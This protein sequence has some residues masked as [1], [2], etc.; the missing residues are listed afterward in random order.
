MLTSS[1]PNANGPY[2]STSKSHDNHFIIRIAVHAAFSVPATIFS[3]TFS[4]SVYTNFQ[5]GI[6]LNDAL[7]RSTSDQYQI[8]LSQKGAC[9]I[10]DVCPSRTK[11]TQRHFF[12]KK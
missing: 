11:F 2:Y 4:K 10:K 8:S 12:K 9:T 3:S 6:Q 7:F 1:V 5:E